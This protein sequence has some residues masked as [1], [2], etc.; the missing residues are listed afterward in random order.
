M[1][2]DKNTV[3]TL[4]YKLQQGDDE[5]EL[6]EQT[7]DS[8]PLVFLYGAGNMIPDFETNLSGKGPG[9]K[10]SFEIGHQEAYGAYNPDAVVTVPIDTFM[11]NGELAKE[12]LEVGR[13]I[14]M[15]DQHGNQLNGTIQE[16]KKDSVVMD[17]NHPLAGV[18]LHFDVEIKD[19]R[20]ATESEMQ[21]GHVHGEGGHQH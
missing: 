3:V 7:F 5:G 2:I 18:D 4:H 13:R 19:V 11:V 17:F 21:H 8:E 1:Q 10:V 12:L 9:D 15:S 20:E 14:P 16:V 6:I